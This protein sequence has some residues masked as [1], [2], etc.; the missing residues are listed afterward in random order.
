M[1]LNHSVGLLESEIVSGSPQCKCRDTIQY[2]KN[3]KWTNDNK[4][5]KHLALWV[6][7]NNKTNKITWPPGFQGKSAN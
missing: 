2:V 5:C 4:G 1:P 6:E 3:Y 7:N